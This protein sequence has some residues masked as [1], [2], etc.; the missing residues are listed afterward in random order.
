VASA[1]QLGPPL[2]HGNRCE[3]H[4]ASF[5][6]GGRS[7]LTAS[8]D[9]HARLWDLPQ[10]LAGDVGRLILWVEVMTGKQLD[11]RGAYRDL[12]AATW[13]LRRRRLAELG[14]PPVEEG[15]P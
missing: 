4:Q 1:H 9:G 8:N 11:D 6:P 13:D 2:P 15:V 12:D 14:G 10:P 7:V 5:A 3:V